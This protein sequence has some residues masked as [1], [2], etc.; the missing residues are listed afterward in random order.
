[1]SKLLQSCQVQNQFC[2]ES[3]VNKQI[4]ETADKIAR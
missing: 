2:A 1:M 4:N 3:N